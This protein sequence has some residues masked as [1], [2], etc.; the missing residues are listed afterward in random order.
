M[1]DLKKQVKF[2]YFVE[3]MKEFE[4]IKKLRVTNE[5]IDKILHRMPGPKERK[6]KIVYE[7]IYDDPR[8]WNHALAIHNKNYRHQQSSKKYYERNKDK[9]NRIRRE[10]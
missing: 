4:I 8:L 9:I 6:S 10:K 7:N 5:Y 1:L 2:L 3:G